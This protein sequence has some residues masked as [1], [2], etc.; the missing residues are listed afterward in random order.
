MAVTI[1]DTRTLVDHADAVGSWVSPVGG[2]S[3]TLFT[4][5]PAPV[6]AT[7]CLGIAV[8]IETSDILFPITAVDL[9]D[10]LVYVWVLANGTMETLVNGGVAVILRDATPDEI[11]YHIAGSDVAGFRHS[12]GPVGWQCVVI[13]TSTLP[14]NTTALAGTLVGLDVTVING[15]GAMFKTLSKALGG[16][17]NC[18]VDTIRFGNDGLVIAG[19]TTGARGTFD[20]IATEDRSTTSG[21][22]YGICREL[23]AGVFGLQGPLTFGLASASA[24]HWFQ[25]TDVTVVFEDRGIGTDKYFFNLA[26]N[27]TDAGHFQL[28]LAAGTNSGSNGCN[29]IVPAGVGA[30][31]DFSDADFDDVLL[32]DSDFIGFS[33]GVTFSSDPTN[34][35]GHEVF[36][37]AFTLCGQI[38]PGQV[39]IKNCSVVISAAAEAML[40]D[41][42]NTLLSGL[43]F[44]SDGTGHAIRFR[45]TGA[46]PFSYTLSDFSYDSY[47]ASD[48][49]T[50]N[51][52]ILIDPVTSSADITLTKSGGDTPS[53][54]LAAGYT[55][56]FTLVTSSVTTT[57][58]VLDVTDGSAIQGVR[59]L[60]TASDST[61]PLPFEDPVTITRSGPTATVSHSAHG[62]ATGQK[63][64]IEDADQAEYN[65]IQT[66][67]VVDADSYSYTVSGTPATPATGTIIS[68][69]AI[70]DGLTDVAGKISDTRSLSANQP[71]TGQARK[72]TS[73]PVYKDGPI[74]GTI[75]NSAGLP[76]TVQLIPDE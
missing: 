10:T 38:D 18:F 48:G 36:A 54:M 34:A 46:G 26:A 57:I 2:E 24:N 75:D 50:G 55:G 25:D 40:L 29:I 67:T 56:T 11:G 21:T 61:G 60:V 31:M 47:A 74:T 44:S 30:T 23:G 76:V 7:G 62:L 16:A 51:E 19:G 41:G 63:T 13:D 64:I 45:P 71:V 3:I 15:I 32:Y 43:S 59:V 37:C 33:N 49:S 28:G 27:A 5:D 14:S 65:G 17:S 6:E 66:I 20:E 72:M 53:I 22:A 70:I 52:A 69:G 35:P 39:N 68:T 12:D 4:T 8:S 42:T 73:S 9:T 58:T 1:T